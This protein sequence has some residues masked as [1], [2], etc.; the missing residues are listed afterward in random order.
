MPTLPQSMLTVMCY[1][2]LLSLASATL[3]FNIEWGGEG[4][5]MMKFVFLDVHFDIEE[6]QGY[7]SKCANNSVQGCR[8]TLM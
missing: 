7:D 1:S 5:Q 6:D 3:Y 2:L 8:A 4:G